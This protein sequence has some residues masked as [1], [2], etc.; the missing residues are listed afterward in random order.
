MKKILFFLFALT[1]LGHSQWGMAATDWQLDRAHSAIYFTVDHIFSKIRGQFNDFSS[2]IKFDPKDLG[3][4]SFYFEIATKS[5]DT[6]NGKR[7]KHLQSSDF[8]DSKNHQSLVF[9]STAIKDM[10][11]A[12]YQVEGKLKV[13]GVAYDL[14]LPLVLAGIKDHP[15]AKEQRVAGFNGELVVD[16]LALGIGEGK[17]YD[18][19]V[20][21][22]DVSILVSLEL[23]SEK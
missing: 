14:T 21:G 2:E 17:F 22:K 12:S 4:S 1:F 10:G 9:Q 13:R 5:I 6:G 16:R 15:V 11:D 19:G 20:V 8:F 3:G 18:L 7:D 23:L